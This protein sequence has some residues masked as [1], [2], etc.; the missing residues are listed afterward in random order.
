MSA[1]HVFYLIVRYSARC[2]YVTTWTNMCTVRLE[3]EISGTWNPGWHKQKSFMS[4][5]P[6]LPCF[7]VRS[8]I[9]QTFFPRILFPWLYFQRLFSGDFPSQIHIYGAV[10]VVYLFA[11]LGCGSMQYKWRNFTCLC[12]NPEWRT[13]LESILSFWLGEARTDSVMTNQKLR[14]ILDWPS[15]WIVTPM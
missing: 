12:H 1:Q 5:W 10:L 15:F 8:R 9:S 2:R 3:S 4:Y 14:F 7:S 6:D 11:R 13:S